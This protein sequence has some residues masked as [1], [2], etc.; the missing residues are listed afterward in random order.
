MTT[1][2]NFYTFSGVVVEG[3]KR[4]R[5]LGFPT[6]NLQILD[7]ENIEFPVS[8]VYAGTIVYEGNT[9]KA[10]ISV[11]SNT[12]FDQK[13]VTIEA[14]ILDFDNDIYGKIISV[15][16]IKKLRDMVKFDSIENLVKQI[17]SDVKE[18]S[19]TVFL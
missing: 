17:Q 12:T 19:N 13:E 1:D 8:G 7:S 18:V 6:A 11:G 14:H 15:V 4:G 5:L 16:L 10:G 2:S 9:Y 3:K